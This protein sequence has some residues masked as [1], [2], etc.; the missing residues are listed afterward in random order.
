MPDQIVTSSAERLA[1]YGVLGILTVVFGVVIW[2][3][4]KE[5]TKERK[6][7]LGVL[8]TERAAHLA[9]VA[10]HT[11][12]VERLQQL[13]IDDAKAYQAQLVELTKGATAALTNVAQ[14]LEQ[15][16]ETLI[17]VRDTMREV[18]DDIRRRP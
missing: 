1:S 13:R 6:E 2:Y 5:G 9:S 12:T 3:L 8:T 11:V 4:W 18:G 10:A 7:L 16:K 14:L 17:E 15:N